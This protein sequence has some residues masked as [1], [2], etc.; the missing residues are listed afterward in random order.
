M[1]KNSK[2]KVIMRLINMLRNSVISLFNHDTIR[3]SAWHIKR[4]GGKIADLCNTK[5]LEYRVNK[6][7]FTLVLVY[8]RQKI[9]FI[10]SHT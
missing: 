5:F 7:T 1:N 10:T 9:S 4:G 8:F 2:W 3:N 6:T